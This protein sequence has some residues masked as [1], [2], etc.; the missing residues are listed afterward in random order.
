M[1]KKEELLNKVTKLA[2]DLEFVGLM[3]NKAFNHGISQPTLPKDLSIRLSEI[4]KELTPNKFNTSEEWKEIL[5]TSQLRLA[6]HWLD[7]IG[8]NLADEIR[9]EK[10]KED[11]SLEQLLRIKHLLFDEANSELYAQFE[12]YSDDKHSVIFKGGDGQEYRLTVTKEEE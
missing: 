7:G 2:E 3:R 10:A 9:A 12:S 8:L 6:I 4:E 11:N 1:T 5:E